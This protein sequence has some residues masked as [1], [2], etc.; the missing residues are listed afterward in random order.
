M[1]KKRLT[2]ENYLIE[3]KRYKHQFKGSSIISKEYNLSDKIGEGT[4]GVVFKATS[5]STKNQVAI[6]KI[7]VH[8]AKDGVSWF[9]L[10]GVVIHLT[11]MITVPNNFN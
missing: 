10:F 3:N 11:L 1:N 5:R 9:F 8:T 7:L 6:K 4:F 2:D